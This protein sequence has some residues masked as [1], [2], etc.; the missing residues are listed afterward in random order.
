MNEM[1]WID[2]A[3]GLVVLGLLAY[4]VL[5]GADFGGG[6][7]DLFATG[8]RKEEQRDAINHAMGP[9]WEANHV[10]LIFVIVLLF[11]CFPYGYSPLVT[12]L[13]IPLH[14]ALLGIM[15]RGAAF[16]FRN[17]R[18]K[19]ATLPGEHLHTPVWQTVFG[20]SSTITPV[21]LGAAF[22]CLTSGAVRVK[23]GAVHLS[24]ALPWLTP[25]AIGCGLLALAT[26]AYLA[27]VYLCVETGGELRE[28]FRRRAIVG[29]TATAALAATVLLLA[30]FEAR[31]FFDRL[32]SAGTLPVVI[33][34]LASF[35]LSAWAVFTRR[36]TLARVF[37]AGEIALLLL[38]WAAAQ[39]PFLVY[40]DLRLSD[41]AGPVTTI[42]FLVIAAVTGMAVLVPSLVLLFRVFKGQPAA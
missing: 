1:L 22:G 36:Y 40:P 27:A 31:W 18:R 30:Y 3:A 2:L 23:E 17:Y 21:L 8:P 20:V 6:I 14:L 42:R 38:G 15:L 26:C 41:A 19:K 28:D 39:Y 25:Y 32:L 24:A 11:T 4:A 35:G 33:A 5:A 10:W 12:A 9:V 29:G 13:F 37:A 34:G 7:W 16:V